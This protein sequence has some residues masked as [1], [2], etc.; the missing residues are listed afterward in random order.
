MLGNSNTEA[1]R[2]AI[3]LLMASGG[4]APPQTNAPAAF[5]GE[6]VAGD[7]NAWPTDPS[8]PADYSSGFTAQGSALL[9]DLGGMAPTGFANSVDTQAV[10]DALA[11]SNYGSDLGHAHAANMADQAMTALGI[12]DA[13]DTSHAVNT[14]VEEG[15]YTSPS[16]APAPAYDSPDP[17][18]T[19]VGLPNDFTTS[20]ASLD[21]GPTGSGFDAGAAIAADVAGLS[22][23]NAGVNDAVAGYDSGVDAGPGS[24]GGGGGGAGGGGSK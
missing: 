13:I 23:L 12:Y 7:P 14:A 11:S 2:N 6:A 9:G 4:G 10:T 21:T 16:P 18:S 3:A 15:G 5:M 22:G 24:E 19:I 17:S 1:M 20:Q 8:D